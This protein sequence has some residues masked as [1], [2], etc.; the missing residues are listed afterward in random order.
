MLIRLA[1]CVCVC[2]CVCVFVCVCVCVCVLACI[3][4]RW[5]CPHLCCGYCNY[6]SG[7][8]T[9]YIKWEQHIIKNLLLSFSLPHSLWKYVS[10]K[11]FIRSVC[12]TIYISAFIA[13]SY[14]LFLVR[15]EKASFC[16]LSLNSYRGWKKLL[17][18]DSLHTKL[19]GRRVKSCYMLLIFVAALKKYIIAWI[20]GKCF[21]CITCFFI[22]CMKIKLL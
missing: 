7:T 9:E 13:C 22:A 21:S 18:N 5:Y 11:D 16:Y 17:G 20:S 8:A 14:F 15:N 19:L 3:R 6:P 12:K 4:P 10:L 1:V 2:V